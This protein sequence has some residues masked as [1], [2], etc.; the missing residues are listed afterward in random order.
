L[1]EN[2]EPL[3]TFED[4]DVWTYEYLVKKGNNHS[5]VCW[6]KGRHDDGFEFKVFDL[7]DELLTE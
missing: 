7:R 6:F 5:M 3:Y 4:D 1:K 2:Q